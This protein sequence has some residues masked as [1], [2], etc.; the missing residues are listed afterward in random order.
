MKPTA[1]AR[2]SLVLAAVVAG[3][4]PA[5]SST[6]PDT[7]GVPSASAEARS[8]PSL[9]PA[10]S[11]AP[12]PS[13]PTATATAAPPSTPAAVRI[14]L[15]GDG[16]LGL[17]VAD[18][19]AYVAAHDS[20]ELVVVDLATGDAEAF[21]IG[22]YG[23]RVVV[24]GPGRVAIGR[25]DR[26]GEH[27][28][29]EQIR[30]PGLRATPTDAGPVDAIEAAGDGRVWGFEKAGSIVLVDPAAGETIG[31]ASIDIAPNEHIDVVGAAGDA[32]ASSDST[33]VRRIGGEPLAVTATIETGGGVPFVED[34]GLVWGARAD[35][36]W[37]IDPASDAVS[38]RVPLEGVIEILDLDVEGDDAWIAVRHPGRLGAVMR[39]DLASGDVLLD[40]PASLPAAIEIAG[41][42]AWVTDYETGEL[43][44]FD[45]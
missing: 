38:R 3:C 1:A 33:P 34:G 22:S 15:P 13:S 43:L 39:V 10:S 23:V 25:Y 31:R 28:P 12:T 14:G 35:E 19:R 21:P 18:G 6:A 9:A 45:R 4:A 24:L 5:S 7:R 26:D 36:V 40:T 20:G 29:I 44:G 16:P 42:R 41:D 30:L 17:D 27:A 37:A 8:S 2:A 32:F 11:V